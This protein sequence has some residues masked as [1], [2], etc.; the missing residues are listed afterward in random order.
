MI[1]IDLRMATALRRAGRTDEAAA[2]VD[3]IAQQARG[4]FE[5]VPE[6]FDRTTGD[7][8]GEVPMVGFGAGA[9]VLALSGLRRRPARRRRRPPRR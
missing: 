9:Y 5:L 7:Y 4:N 6:N 2:L 3:W 8:A 1:V